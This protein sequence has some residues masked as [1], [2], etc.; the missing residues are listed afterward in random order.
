EAT[1]DYQTQATVASAYD[2]G[3]KFKPIVATAAIDSGAMTEDKYFTIPPS[4]KVYDRT[5]T[6]SHPHGTLEYTLSQIIEHSSNIG[7]VLV[8]RTIGDET[9]A[10]YATRFGFGQD[11]GTDFGY[12]SDGL[13]KDYTEWAPV[14][15]ANIPFGQGMTC[16]V[17]QIARAYAVFANGGTL[18]TPH[19]MLLNTKVDG[20]YDWPS[21]RIISI[22]TAERLQLVLRR[23]VT[24]GTASLA[25]VGD[26][27]V[28][29][30]TGTA[31]YAEEGSGGYYSD[32]Y[33]YG[34]AGFIVGGDPNFVVV[35]TIK[36]PQRGAE[37]ATP[38]FSEVMTYVTERYYVKVTD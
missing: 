6:D 2:P 10:M 21:D 1:P 28:A 30:K 14:D 18:V 11:A 25:A 31:Q 20:P 36:N 16:S 4:L 15:S 22:D 12:V 23:V 17:L 13:L 26:Y 32:R 7:T 38:D 29:G 33:I 5:I 27:P 34:F 8:A 37:T 19:F 35:I 3:S 24:R 9:V